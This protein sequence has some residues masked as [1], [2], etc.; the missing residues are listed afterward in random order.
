MNTD[1]VKGK[2]K[3]IAGEVQEHVGRAVGSTEQEVKGH[4]R[5]M[6][7]KT[8]KAYGDAKEVAKDIVRDTK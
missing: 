4:N 6:D 2:A 3:E 1:Q 7:G 5:E 8:Q